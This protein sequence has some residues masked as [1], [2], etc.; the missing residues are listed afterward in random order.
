MTGRRSINQATTISSRLR[1]PLVSLIVPVYNEEAAIGLFMAQVN[2]MVRRSDTHFELVFVNDGSSDNTL[3]VIKAFPSSCPMRLVDL[4]RN[5]GK[6]AAMTAGLAMSKG[7]AAVPIDVDLQ[8]P[9]EVIDQFIVEWKNGHDMVYGVRESRGCDTPMKRNTSVLFYYIFNKLSR[10]KI[11][12]NVGDFRLMDRKVIDAVLSLEEKNRFM[13]GMFSWVGFKTKA[14]PYH[15]APRAAGNTSWNY[16]K[17]WNFAL[18]GVIGFSSLPLR[19]WTYIGAFI[20]LFSFLFIANIVFRKLVFGNPVDG[21]SSLMVTV[22]FFGGIQLISLG[23]IGEYLGR[24]FI[25]SKNRPVYLVDTVEEF[26]AHA[27]NVDEAEATEFSRRSCR[28]TA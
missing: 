10:D 6:E 12:E 15:R 18:D 27:E 5:F 8:D 4:S 3:S 24:L 23:I 2:A 17:L 11:P 19:V 25:E 16:W 9:I 7:D 26:E 13:K 28:E 20:S 22:L 21:W 14:V 1:S